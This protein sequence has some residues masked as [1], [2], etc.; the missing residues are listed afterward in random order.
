MEK[1]IANTLREIRD[2]FGKSSS[3]EAR[4]ATRKFVPT[5][6]Q[7]LGVRLPVINELARQYKKGGFDLATKLWHAGTYEEQLLAAKILGLAARESPE[8]TIA[9][10]ME[11]ST[12]ISDWAVC[13]TLGLQSVKTITAKQENKIIDA[14]QELLKS[15]VMWQ[16]R[17]GIVLLTHYANVP[18]KQQAILAMLSPLRT[19][20]EH[21][22]KKAIA[23][24]DRDLAKSKLK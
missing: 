3:E 17:L 10:L 5:S 1:S 11:F 15:P 23:W 18:A 7:V 22:I 14:A 19:E 9:L 12:N 8:R 16:R 13:D 21:Y 20:T 4:A 2:H 24:I 6:V